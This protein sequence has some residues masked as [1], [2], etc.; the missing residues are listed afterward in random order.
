MLL[1]PLSVDFTATLS[2]HNSI[3]IK[4]SPFVL[5]SSARLDNR[6]FICIS[7]HINMHV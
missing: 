5:N 2:L 3:I 6:G 1:K 4:A 7:M